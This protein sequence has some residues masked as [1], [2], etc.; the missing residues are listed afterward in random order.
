MQLES[1][2]QT[3]S[4]CGPPLWPLHCCFPIFCADSFIICTFFML[5][6][7]HGWTFLLFLPSESPSLFKIPFK[8]HISYEATSNHSQPNWFQFFLMY[9][10]ICY[11]F[12]FFNCLTS[13]D[14]EGQLNSKT[15]FLI[16]SIP[17]L[18]EEL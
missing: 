17:G 15:Y 11:F 1:V 12:L 16:I 13:A 14:E 4:W 6:Y 10:Y 7:L 2:F 5:C 9:I 3:S 8:P 18:L